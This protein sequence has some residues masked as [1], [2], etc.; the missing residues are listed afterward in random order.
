MIYSKIRSRRTVGRSESCGRDREESLVKITIKASLSHSV[1]A[2]EFNVGD[3]VVI[4]ALWCEE[5]S[6]LRND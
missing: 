4:P 6:M 2:S 1:I 5:I 3:F